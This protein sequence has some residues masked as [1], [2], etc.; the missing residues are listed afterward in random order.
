MQR[1]RHLHELF[2]KLTLHE[3]LGKNFL[4]AI[5]VFPQRLHKGW[6]GK[7]CYNNTSHK[8]VYKIPDLE[9]TEISNIRIS[10][11]WWHVEHIKIH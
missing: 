3:L 5:W 7:C 10:N 8:V 2:K 4:K 9:I 6:E 1:S 11:S